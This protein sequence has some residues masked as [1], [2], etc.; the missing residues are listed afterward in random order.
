M[1]RHSLIRRWMNVASEGSLTVF[2]YHKVPTL[3]P[4]HIQGEVEAAEF[5]RV[6]FNYLEWFQFLPLDEALERMR[7][8]DLPR[9]AAAITFDDGYA[10]W[11]E[12]IVPLLREHRIPATFFITSNQLGKNEPFW[13]ERI[14]NAVAARGPGN[15][16]SG[17]EWGR[18]HIGTRDAEI[19][20]TVIALQEKL[21]YMVLSEREDAIGLLEEGLP[22]IASFQPFTAADVIRLRDAGFQIGGHSKNHPILA[23][24]TPQEAKDEIGGCKEELEAI[25]HQPVTQFAYPNGRPGTDFSAEQVKLVRQAG[26][27][28]AVTTAPGVVR[29]NTDVFQL[30]RFTPWA[31]SD[32]RSALQII[33]NMRVTPQVVN[34]E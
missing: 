5:S 23:R 14:A 22:K 15:L 2:Q 25:L 10:E 18:K 4:S 11:F 26:Y 12:H 24:C 33:R 6:F 28:L 29:A 13:H 8:G 34:D 20:S 27:Q 9:R 3:S 31:R 16:P 30:P 7:R 1:M 32:W 19:A 17:F 21:K